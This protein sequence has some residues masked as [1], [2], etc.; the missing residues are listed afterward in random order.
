ME[1]GKDHW[2]E[3]R[4]TIQSLFSEGFTKIDEKL[5]SEISFDHD[6]V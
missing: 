1:L 6:K 3:A 5:M 2:H 4:V